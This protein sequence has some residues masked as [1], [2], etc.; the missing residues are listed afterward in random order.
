MS[1]SHGGIYSND[2]KVLGS[3]YLE[4]SRWH[5]FSVKK[6]WYKDHYRF[7]SPVSNCFL[8]E[9]PFDNGRFLASEI[10][11]FFR[12]ELRKCHYRLIDN[13][14]VS[15]LISYKSLLMKGSTPEYYHQM[16]PII[17]ILRRESYLK[18]CPDEDV[19]SLY[20]ECLDQCSRLY[21]SYMTSVR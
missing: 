20:W 10:R 4:I 1:H 6:E 21:N 2:Y 9:S 19:R 11:D 15:I 5:F 16:L 8:G 12:K 14:Y 7:R 18:I 17:D 13:L 3:R